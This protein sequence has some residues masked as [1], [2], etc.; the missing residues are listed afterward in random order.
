MVVIFSRSL[1]MSFNNNCSYSKKSNE[2]KSSCFL[3]RQI[4]HAPVHVWVVV[5]RC[6]SEV[7]PVHGHG[8]SLD[9]GLSRQLK[10]LKNA[11]LES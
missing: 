6:A 1:N 8:K 5:T 4:V 10:S 2:F 7:T 11:K 3:C 9:R